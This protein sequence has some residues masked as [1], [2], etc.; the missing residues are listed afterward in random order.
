[1]SDLHHRSRRASSRSDAH[2][3]THALQQTV[4]PTQPQ[5]SP[6]AWTDTM[7]SLVSEIGQRT[8]VTPFVKI[9]SSL[10]LQYV[11]P[12]EDMVDIEYY[13]ESPACKLLDVGSHKISVFNNWEGMCDLVRAAGNRG[14]PALRIIKRLDATGQRYSSLPA[15][16]HAIAAQC[17]V[18]E[19]NRE[20]IEKYIAAT[21]LAATPA[22][23][24]RA[25]LPG[26]SPASYRH[27]PDFGAGSVGPSAR[28]WQYVW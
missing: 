12:V 17:A 7:S 19:G 25:R 15:L 22:G 26:S 21:N 6:P 24:A 27:K 18:D 23:A 20:A 2:Q 13:L 14:A 28:G 5:R 16:A 10:L 9:Y 11:P 1:M 4:A 8:G 3:T